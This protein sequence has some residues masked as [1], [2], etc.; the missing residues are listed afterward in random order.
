MNDETIWTLVIA[1]ICFASGFELALI[2]TFGSIRKWRAC[3]DAY[4]SGRVTVLQELYD[5]IAERQK[6]VK[7][8]AWGVLNEILDLIAG[9]LPKNIREE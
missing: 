6:Q 9:M 2:L 8:E 7:G 5:R 3:G 4:R 1:A